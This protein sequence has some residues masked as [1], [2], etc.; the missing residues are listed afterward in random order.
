LN[1]FPITPIPDVLIA[2][3]TRDLLGKYGFNPTNTLFGSSVCPDEI[4][5]DEND[6]T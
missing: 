5:R 1:L 6:L 3:V 2:P 4:N